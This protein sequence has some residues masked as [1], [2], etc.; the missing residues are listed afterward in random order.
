MGEI[1]QEYLDDV[2]DVL[3]QLDRGEIDNEAASKALNLF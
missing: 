3:S 1:H 2:A